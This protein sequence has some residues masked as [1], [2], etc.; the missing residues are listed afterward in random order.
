MCRLS[1]LAVAA[2]IAVS[3][4]PVS[5][6][7]AE[8]ANASVR[9]SNFQFTLTDLDPSDGRAPGFRWQPNPWSGD[10]LDVRGYVRVGDSYLFSVPPFY[11]LDFPR[12]RSVVVSKDD[13]DFRARIGA[14]IPGE[15]STLQLGA[16]IGLHDGALARPGRWFASEEAS[17]NAGLVLSPTRS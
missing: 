9:L 6:S 3:A 15:L 16:D 8:A 14:S 4:V 2:L 7:A 5:A 1:S 17:F 13:M 10:N 12:H 11:Y